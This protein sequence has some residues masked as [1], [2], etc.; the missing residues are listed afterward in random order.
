MK[1]KLYSLLEQG[2]LKKPH[3]VLVTYRSLIEP[4]NTD[5][6]IGQFTL[7]GVKSNDDPPI[8]LSDTINL[9]PSADAT[10]PYRTITIDIDPTREVANV[11]YTLINPDNANNLNCIVDHIELISEQGNLPIGLGILEPEA[12]AATSITSTGF[13]ANWTEIE[14]ATG[15]KIDVSTDIEFTTFVTNYENKDIPSG[16]TVSLVVTG[17]TEDTCYFYRVRAYNAEFTSMNSNIIHAATIIP[18]TDLTDFYNVTIGHE[19]FI[20]TTVNQFSDKVYPT[21]WNGD[22]TI[23]FRFN[24]NGQAAELVNTD[25]VGFVKNAA[26]FFEIGIYAADAK[27]LVKHAVDGGNYQAVTTP[28]SYDGVEHVFVITRAWNSGV[29]YI[30]VK[31]DGVAIYSASPTVYGII[32]PELPVSVGDFITLMSFRRFAG[33]PSTIPG[34]TLGKFMISD[35]VWDATDEANYNAG[36]YTSIDYEYYNPLVITQLAAEP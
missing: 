10:N 26:N 34:R 7:Y 33:T 8:A 32:P 12:T 17:L 29:P 28:L 25:M 30:I 5:T 14:E 21:T 36:L 35:Y 20:Q 19:S 16:S 13:T 31:R 22:Y 4:T 1:S 11:F 3:K 2:I 18:D 27:M 9:Y 23:A 24:N 6:T 15:Y